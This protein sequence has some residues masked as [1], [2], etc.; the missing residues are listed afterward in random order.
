MDMDCLDRIVDFIASTG[1]PI[2]EGT[3]PTDAFLPGIYVLSGGLVFDREA[4]RWP[5]DLLHEAGHL[6]V[7]P[8]SLRSLMQGDASLPESVPHASEVE[9]TAWA[10]AALCQLGLDPSVLF[11][12]GGYHGCS[13]RLIQA[14]TLGVYPG[15]SG[16]ADAGMTHVGPDAVR[17]SLP[18]YPAML[19]WLRP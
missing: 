3:V 2:R 4:L 16:L 11:H 12:E 14:F 13:S 7:A 1:I 10:W 17:A 8:A 5:G 19:R 6:A 15:A 18:V 9:A